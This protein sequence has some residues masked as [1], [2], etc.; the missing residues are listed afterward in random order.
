MAYADA[1]NN[2]LVSR[3]A[4]VH[5]TSNDSSCRK[6]IANLLE[7]ALSNNKLP[8]TLAQ[9]VVQRTV[10]RRVS[11]GLR[12]PEP[13]LSRPGRPGGAASLRRDQVMG[14]APRPDGL[15]LIRDS[16]DGLARRGTRGAC[17]LGQCCLSGAVDLNN[18]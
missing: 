18:G 13:G 6:Q 8:N 7:N 11:R 12:Q 10:S 17:A 1:C 3:R 2:H 14:V 9:G 4:L 5:C 15:G 16:S